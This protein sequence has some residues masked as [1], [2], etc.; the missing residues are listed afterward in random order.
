MNPLIKFPWTTRLAAGAT[1]GVFL[2]AQAG[3]IGRFGTALIYAASWII[4]LHVMV[5]EY[6]L[7][8]H[9]HANSKNQRALDT[10]AFILFLGGILAFT[11]APLWCAFMAGVFALA[12]VKYVLVEQQTPQPALRQYARE[13][14]RWEAPSV[15]LFAALA[16]FMDLRAPREGKLPVAE[17]AILA[18]SILFAV[19]MVAVRHIYRRVIRAGREDAP[20]L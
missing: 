10:L 14:I 18:A 11:S 16:V 12:I 9:L 15:L 5:G 6:I 20:R 7:V 19:W 1:T 2:V 8:R 3:R 17:V 4:L 13:K